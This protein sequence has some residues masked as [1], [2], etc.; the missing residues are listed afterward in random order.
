[1]NIPVLTQLAH[2][3]EEILK[4]E[5]PVA[6]HAAAEAAISDAESDPKIRAVTTASVALLDAAQR[7]KQAA[8]TPSS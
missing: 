2:L 4:T 8:G 3:I 6:G 1:M 7:L 5:I